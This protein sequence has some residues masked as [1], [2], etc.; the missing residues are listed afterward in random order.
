MRVSDSVVRPSS[1]FQPT[2]AGEGGRCLAQEAE[3][4]A[5]KLQPTPAGEGGRCPRD[6]ATRLPHRGFNPRPPVRAGDAAAFVVVCNS[7]LVSTHA[8]R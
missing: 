7:D 8:R 2:P 3:A 5:A 4:Y 1:R 6:R